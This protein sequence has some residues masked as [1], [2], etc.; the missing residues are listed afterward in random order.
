[1]HAVDGVAV[2][3]E[4]ADALEDEPTVLEGAGAPLPKF[5][6]ADAAPCSLAM[7]CRGIGS[8]DLFA[9]AFGHGV[10]GFALSCSWRACLLAALLSPATMRP[11]TYSK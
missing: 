8:E 3:L 6:E 10:P 5:W 7:G 9:M 11:A 4:D 1:M 2:V